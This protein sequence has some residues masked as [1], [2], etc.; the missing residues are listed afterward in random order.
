MANI[1]KIHVFC[2]SKDKITYHFRQDY[3]RK[4]HITCLSDKIAYKKKK[5]L[6]GSFSMKWGKCYASCE[7][8]ERNSVGVMP[9]R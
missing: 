9:K 3:N 7:A 4:D 1:R 2:N 6:E 5:E 8:D